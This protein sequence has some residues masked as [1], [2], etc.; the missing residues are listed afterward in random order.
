MNQPDR[1]TVL[2]ERFENW[3]WSFSAPELPEREGQFLQ[4]CASSG[5]RLEQIL[6]DAYQSDETLALAVQKQF[7]C[8]WA[9]VELFVNRY[10]PELLRWFSRW[11]R[12]CRRDYHQELDLAQE[13]VLQFLKHEKKLQTYEPSRA[14]AHWLHRVARNLW[15]AKVGRRRQPSPT[16]K[17]PETPYWIT[18]EEEFFARELDGRLHEALPR[19]PPG[20]REVLVLT[21][22]GL[23]PSDVAP[24]LG[25]P[26]A[27]V[28]RLLHKARQWLAEEL[29]LSQPPSN[30]GSPRQARPGTPEPR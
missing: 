25:L 27:N 7:C 24:Q 11:E 5:V 17:L 2:A 18:P 29:G 1:L 30:R 4:D 19:L 15:I 10:G 14:F 13:L 26:I 12:N 8:K 9:F 23:S 28:Y 22:Q 16:E 6:S 20:Q 21:L 3:V